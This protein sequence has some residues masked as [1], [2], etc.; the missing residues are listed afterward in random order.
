MSSIIS[1]NDKRCTGGNEAIVIG[2]VIVGLVASNAIHCV[3]FLMTITM[4]KAFCIKFK[5]Y[6]LIILKIIT[7]M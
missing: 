7:H 1:K 3:F 5:Q 2:D 4:I 6:L